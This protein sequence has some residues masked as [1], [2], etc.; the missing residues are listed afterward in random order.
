MTFPQLNI[1]P[2][3][4]P[5]TAFLSTPADI[6]IYGGSAGS[7]KSF[8]LLM[9]P[10]RHYQ[11]SRFGTV[12][13]RRNTTQ[14]RNQGGLWDESLGLYNR[15]NGV[16]RETTMDWTFPSGASVKF[17]H[18]EY[19][20]TVHDWH[21]SQIPLIE[22]DELTS[23][24]EYQFW[25]MMSRNRSMS[26]VPGYMRASCN[27][28]ADSWVRKLLDWWIDNDTGFPIKERSGVLRWF[29][30]INDDM[31]WGDS[32]EELIKKY[33]PEQLPKS[34]TFIPSSIFDNQIL[35][36]K[37]PSYLANLR[38]L[39]RVER[40][41]LLNGNW[42][43]RRA[44][45][46]YFQKSYFE[47]LDAEPAGGVAV[48]YWDRASTKPNEQNK[49]PDWTVG[50]K[51]KKLPSGLYVVCHVERFQEAPAEIERRCRNIAGLDGREM[52]IGIE[53]DPGSAGA[54]DVGNYTRKVLQGFRV[55]IYKPSKDKVTRALAYSASAENGNVKLV[56]GKWN[57]AFLTEHENF[58]PEEGSEGKDDQVDSGSGAYNHLLPKVAADWAPIN[59]PG[60]NRFA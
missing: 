44:A 34:L 60:V 19:K 23:F 21:G 5:Q 26:G 31:L 1:K 10:M 53:Q 45:G 15:M 6:G 50:L 30:R 52:E 55:Y 29:I 51:M 40:E 9:E 2:Q 47:I 41:R 35:L 58:P 18:L 3:A 11:N 37:D 36:Q 48:R 20:N 43:I 46:N 42:N 4:G 27:P 16:P 38:A 8:A 12:I 13:F 49:N 24:L 59:L 54:A 56:R 17:A 7:G 14:I 25:Y 32:R 33:G 57:D 22:F 39:P 28:D